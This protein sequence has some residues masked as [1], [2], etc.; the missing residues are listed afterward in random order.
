[1]ARV[2]NWKLNDDIFSWIFM[3]NWI[4]IFGIL[5]FSLGC[6]RVEETLCHFRN[7]HKPLDRGR[8]M[9]YSVFSWETE[10]TPNAN[11]FIHTD[12]WPFIG[13]ICPYE[14]PPATMR[15]V[16]LGSIKIQNRYSFFCPSDPAEWGSRLKIEQSWVRIP[17]RVLTANAYN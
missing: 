4:Y 13:S 17:P 9:P 2:C 14:P 1:M 15:V 12:N 16:I 10:K 8:R 11:F 3:W 5:F 7:W 6:L